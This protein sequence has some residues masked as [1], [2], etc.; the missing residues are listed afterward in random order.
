MNI[1]N[2]NIVSAT[3]EEVILRCNYFK[4]TNYDVYTDPKPEEDP[5]PYEC[6]I[7]ISRELFYKILDEILERK[8]QY[9]SYGTFAGVGYVA[10]KKLK[11]MSPCFLTY[12]DY[13]KDVEDELYIIHIPVPTFRANDYLVDIEHG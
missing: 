1:E 6:V 12:F 13:D 2:I 4:D 9:N 7:Y 3:K 5:W 8:A 10:F 11:K